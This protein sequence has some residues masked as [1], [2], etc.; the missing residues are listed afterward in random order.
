M[1]GEKVNY[2]EELHLPSLVAAAGGSIFKRYDAQ[3]LL[4][5]LNF[6]FG[7]MCKAKK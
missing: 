3:N 4:P 2:E 6:I 5:R 7:R 1:Q